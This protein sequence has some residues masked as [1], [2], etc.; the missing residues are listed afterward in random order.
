ME[1]L[2]GHMVD[3][4]TAK[5]YMLGYANVNIEHYFKG[6]FRRKMRAYD[7]NTCPP[8]W[9]SFHSSPMEPKFSKTTN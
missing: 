4:L 2:G 3:V 1:H 5:K 8:S 7:H 9:T 6:Q